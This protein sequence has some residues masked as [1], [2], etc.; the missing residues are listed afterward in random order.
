MSYV[1]SVQLVKCASDPEDCGRMTIAKLII[2]PGE[3]YLGAL[4]ELL[5][6]ATSFTLVT[7][8][9]TA[10]GVAELAAP[11]QGLLER[12]GQGRIYVAVDKQG[13]NLAPVFEAL[14]ALKRAHGA[15]LSLGLVEQVHGLMHAKAL[16]GEGA[17][18]PRLVVGSANLTS[19]AFQ[20]NHELGVL[21]S[22]LSDD[23]RAAWRRFVYGLAP[24]QLDDEGARGFL[25]SRGLLARSIV[26]RASAPV[27][28]DAASPPAARNPL[29]DLPALPPLVDAPD[30]HLASWIHRGYIV[31]RGRRLLEALTLRV[32][33]EV[34]VNRGL[35][36]ATKDK[37]LGEGAFENQSLGYG[38]RLIPNAEAAEVSREARRVS[39]LLS[40]VTLSLPCFGTWMPQTYWVRYLEAREE[41]RRGGVLDPERMRQ[42]AVE[43]RKALGAGALVGEVE[44]I[45]DRLAE[46]NLLVDGKREAVRDE[47]VVRF[48]RELVQ[49]TPEVIAS[50]VE[51]RTAR[52]SWSPYEST[53]AP[54]RQLMVDLVQ[55]TFAPTYRTGDWPR[56]FRSHAARA[57]AAVVAERLENSGQV[58]DGATAVGILDAA[59]RWENAA[60]PFLEVV[61]EFR[62]L[63]P[64]DME[65]EAP[66]VN[67]LL[68]R[69]EAD[70][71][72][73]AAADAGAES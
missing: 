25:E 34:L 19:G 2:S 39:L 16:Y 56:R 30:V 17:L 26:P 7:A 11:I 66:T 10:S 5:A 45:L 3:D 23:V 22:D 8:F 33:S 24:R 31:G 42:L 59:A 57:L 18:G 6:T 58:A 70:D 20:Q 49:R 54:Y 50:C 48:E 71:E 36:R 47:L 64:D 37:A 15:K 35:L 73:D 28:G 32:P 44:V 9:A 41:L 46:L 53:E 65:F 51:F 55:A 43:R 27:N 68:G 72:V 4:R 69:D 61:E 14:L 67:E 52:Q 40:K 60:R 12:G 62:R 63:V 38:L 13:F 21:L 1:L 29:A